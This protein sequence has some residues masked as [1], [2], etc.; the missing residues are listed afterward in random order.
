MK[1][2]KTLLKILQIKKKMDEES[3]GKDHIQY[4]YI[5]IQNIQYY[6]QFNTNISK[7][8]HTFNKLIHSLCSTSLLNYLV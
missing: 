8:T 5:Y 6:I 1:N 4:I 3:Q 2:S 7:Y